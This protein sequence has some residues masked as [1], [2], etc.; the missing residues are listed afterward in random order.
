MAIRDVTINDRPVKI[1]RLDAAVDIP[2]VRTISLAPACF[3]TICDE[4]CQR[5]YTSLSG[6]YAYDSQRNLSLLWLQANVCAEH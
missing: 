1:D 6:C 5:T 4:N 3:E 2:S